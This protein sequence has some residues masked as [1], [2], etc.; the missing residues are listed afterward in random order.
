MIKIDIVP[1]ES[2]YFKHC[3]PT[4]FK[5]FLILND[6]Q[7]ES[8]SESNGIPIYSGYVAVENFLLMKANADQAGY[9]ITIVQ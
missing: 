4:C 6:I 3:F 9:K 1:S 2:S 8:K 5:T 7:I